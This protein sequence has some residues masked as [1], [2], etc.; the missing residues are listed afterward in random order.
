MGLTT[1]IQH[2]YLFLDV[3][4]LLLQ[5]LYICIDISVVFVLLQNWNVST[6]CNIK[7]KERYVITQQSNEPGIIISSVTATIFQLSEKNVS[8]PSLII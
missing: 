2:F 1:F 7:R 6:C 5:L 3:L 8:Q 4:Q